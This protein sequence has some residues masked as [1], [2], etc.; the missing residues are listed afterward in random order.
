[1]NTETPIA[2]RIQKLFATP[3]IELELPDADKL[4]PV[5]LA[6]IE[7]RRAESPGIQ[8]SNINGWH[9]ET[10]MLK[11]G[12]EAAKTVAL[13]TLQACAR[14]TT[15][16]GA[17]PNAPPRYQMGV[18]MW[19]NSSPAGASNQNHAHAGAIWSAVYFVDDGGDSKE[20]QLSLL[21][22]RF[23]MC[24]MYNSD[25]YFSDENGVRDQNNFKISP[26]P[27]KLVIFPSWLMHGVRPHRGPRDRVSIALNVVAHP[28]RA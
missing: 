25:L 4:N 10:D 3:L 6:L 11:W 28:V 5:L 15:D 24:R 12:G 23:P 14:H 16:V 13:A 26:T 21:D 19:A 2:T 22:P 18:Q 1:M 8:R 7:A 27:G 17:K 9:S 20:G